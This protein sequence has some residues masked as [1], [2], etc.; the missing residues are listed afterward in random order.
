MKEEGFIFVNFQLLN[1]SVL[2]PAP[3]IFQQALLG[4][5]DAS[6]ELLLS[7]E[8]LKDNFTPNKAISFKKR[9]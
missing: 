8:R 6:A 7:S 5:K 3:A 4:E 2:P 9:C 1:C